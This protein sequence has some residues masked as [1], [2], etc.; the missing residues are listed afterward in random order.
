[1]NIWQKAMISSLQF[2][3]VR[4]V[5]KDFIRDLVKIKDKHDK[6]R[7]GSLS[8]GQDAYLIKLAYR[9]RGQISAGIAPTSDKIPPKEYQAITEKMCD[10]I[11]KERKDLEEYERK[12]N[13]ETHSS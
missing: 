8:P 4:A 12:R 9:Y 6:G 1:M 7:R 10:R 5:E 2:A 3:R 11:L 13:V